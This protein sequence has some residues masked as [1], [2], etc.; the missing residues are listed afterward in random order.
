MYGLAG[1]TDL[2]VSEEGLRTATRSIVVTDHQIASEEL[3]LDR[4]MVGGYA[5]A[6]S[7]ALGNRCSKSITPTHS[8]LTEI[9]TIF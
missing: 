1:P 2:I 8:G 3:A 6:A 5:L 4:D 9:R 7:M